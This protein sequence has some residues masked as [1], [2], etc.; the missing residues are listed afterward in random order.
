MGVREG[1]TERDRERDRKRERERP[2]ETERDRERQKETERQ[3]DRK[4][5]MHLI[6]YTYA[7]PG[8][9][10]YDISVPLLEDSS[11]F[12]L[13]LAIIMERFICA[14]NNINGFYIN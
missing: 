8:I 13:L 14:C 1:G 10:R 7:T 11:L 6:E 3:G 9:A 5:D 2:R 12:V 4:R